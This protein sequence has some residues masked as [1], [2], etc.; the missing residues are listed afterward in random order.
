MNYSSNE[1][2]YALRQLCSRLFYPDAADDVN[3]IDRWHELHLLISQYAE[4]LYPLR[5]AD[6]TEEAGLCLSLLMAY[7]ASVGY[8]GSKVQH[9]LD[10]SH[11]V[12]PLLEPS[13][14]KCSLLTFCYMEVEDPALLDEI[15]QIRSTW[16]NRP[17]LEEEWQLLE[18]L[19]VVEESLLS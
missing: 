18:T 17:L 10:R 1:K 2:A 5:G 7:R 16:E 4:E 3:C 15:H 14:L 9:V 12:L 6:A 8:D 19:S 11:S 13:L